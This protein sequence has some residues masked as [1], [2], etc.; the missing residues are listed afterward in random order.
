MLW[1][2]SKFEPEVTKIDTKLINFNSYKFLS[3][4]KIKLLTKFFHE[5]KSDILQKFTHT[6]F[7]ASKYSAPNVHMTKPRHRHRLERK[8]AHSQAIASLPDQ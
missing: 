1:V 5:G 8:Q 4:S 7:F 2:N 6:T 3:G